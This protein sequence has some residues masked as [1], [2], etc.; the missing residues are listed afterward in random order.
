[1]I[2]GKEIEYAAQIFVQ[3]NYRTLVYEASFCSPSPF[4]FLV[5]NGTRISFDENAEVVVYGVEFLRRLDKLLP[6]FEKRRVVNYLEWC[7]FFK[8]ML[9]D[10]PDPFALTIFKFYKTLNQYNL[11]HT[12]VGEGVYHRYER[13]EG[14]LA[15]L[16]HQNQ[17]FNADGYVFHLRETPFRP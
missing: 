13:A 11:T 8:T 2:L 9:R 10:L 6:Q 15:W 14:P 1:M 12:K 7:W 5:Q 17:Q 16:C 3:G 4:L